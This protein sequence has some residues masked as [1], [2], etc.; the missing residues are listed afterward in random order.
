MRRASTTWRA[1]WAAPSAWRSLGVFIDRRDAYHDAVIRDSVTA[2][3]LIGQDH[4][5]ASSAGFLAQHGDKAFAHLQALGQLAGRS[6]A[7]G[8][9]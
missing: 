8:R 7:S 9:S 5:A 1:T 6:T 2:N 4:M 3:S